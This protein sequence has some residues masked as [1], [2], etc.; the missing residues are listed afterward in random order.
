VVNNPAKNG[1]FK[2]AILGT[3]VPALTKEPVFSSD[4]KGADTVFCQ[5]VGNGA[6]AIL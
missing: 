3:F 1:T 4:S 5:V 6:V 2:P